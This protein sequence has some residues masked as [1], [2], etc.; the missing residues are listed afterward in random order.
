MSHRARLENQ[1]SKKLVRS[2]KTNLLGA[3]RTDRATVTR[4]FSVSA[5]DRVHRETRII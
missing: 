3:V 1:F 4:E 2:R 5:H